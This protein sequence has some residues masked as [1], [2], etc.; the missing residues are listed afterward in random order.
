MTDVEQVHGVE[1]RYMSVAEAAAAL[2]VSRMTMYRKIHARQVRVSQVG[3]KLRV[4]V[5]DI[6]KMSEPTYLAAEEMD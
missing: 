2:G 4:F 3:R 6:K 1:T 5:P